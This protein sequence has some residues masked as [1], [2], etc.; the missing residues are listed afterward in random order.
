MKKLRKIAGGDTYT[1]IYLKLQLLSLSEN[2]ILY[3]E[4]LEDS[5]EEELSIIL[6]EDIENVKFTLL[7]LM[8]Y[9]LIEKKG[10]DSYFVTEIPYSTG[11]ECDSAPRVRKLRLKEKEKLLQCNENV[12]LEKEIR[13]NSKDIENKKHVDSKESSIND[14]FEKIWKLYP[15][16]KG[17]G[18]I[19]KTQKKK[20]FDI[21]LDE[22]TRCLE[23]VNK[24]YADKNTEEQYMQQGSTFF[25][26][27]YMDYLDCNYA[28]SSKP[29]EPI[30][31][32]RDKTPEELERE[33]HSGYTIQEL[34]ELTGEKLR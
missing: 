16:K 6:D 33:Q 12:T 19:S 13:D 27:G 34:E 9:G 31:V 14:F 4:G 17:K 3:Y 8:K 7:F 10:E 26:S 11:K 29:I 32:E 22:M 18:Q 5:L 24:Y 28:D 20:L 2:G 25:N 23:R 30:I 1:I 15:K 21:G